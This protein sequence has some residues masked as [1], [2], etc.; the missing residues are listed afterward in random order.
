MSF[1]DPFRMFTITDP[2]TGRIHQLTDKKK[3]EAL[4]KKLGAKPAVS[5]CWYAWR[6]TGRQ[7]PRQ[8][9]AD[10]ERPPIPKFCS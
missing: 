9:E 2:K 10:E 1:S 4:A 6:R 5:R 3:V 7:L 8:Y